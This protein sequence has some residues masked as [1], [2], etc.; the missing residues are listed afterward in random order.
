MTEDDRPAK[1]A[2]A[3]VPLSKQQRMARQATELR[4]NLKRRKDKARA[5]ARRSEAE[6]G[7]AADDA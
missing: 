4:A 1:P 2:K 6:P 3:A 5:A 7:E